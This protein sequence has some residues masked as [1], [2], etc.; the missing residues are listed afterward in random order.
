MAITKQSG[1]LLVSSERLYADA[2]GKILPA[3]P[4][5][6]M[7]AGAKTLVVAAGG[8]ISTLV[9]AKYGLLP[10]DVPAAA[11]AAAS[12]PAQKLTRATGEG[13]KDKVEPLTGG[14]VTG[15]KGADAAP[16]KAKDKPEDKGR[17]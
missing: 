12:E 17:R 13:S 5:G 3:G 15:L 1:N 8:E 6:K 7:P 10:D 14:P 2:D 16:N 9:A 11:P 4:D